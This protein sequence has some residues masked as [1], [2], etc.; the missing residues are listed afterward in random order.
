M[1]NARV[2]ITVAGLL[3]VTT[4]AR[5]A[6]DDYHLVSQAQIEGL[7]TPEPA[8][9]SPFKP[10][11]R[12]PS[13]CFQLLANTNEVLKSQARFREPI[14]IVSWGR[15]S[16]RRWQ[17]PPSASVQRVP[18]DEKSKPDWKHQLKV[19]SAGYQDRVDQ[20]DLGIKTFNL[21]LTSVFGALKVFAAAGEIPKW[22]GPAFTLSKFLL[23][24]SREQ[25]KAMSK[26]L[27]DFA[28]YELKNKVNFV[29][30][31]TPISGPEGM[32]FVREA[33]YLEGEVKVLPVQVCTAPTE[34]MLMPK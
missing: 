10:Y 12:V 25:N 7:P 34:P 26:F 32:D 20:Q 14:A 23:P 24:D 3:L 1:C 15:F 18:M 28:D 5:G 16:H 8:L 31:V 9:L 30:A 13:N 29:M 33:Y 21:L 19:V 17:G 2:A 4:I 11:Q 6:D 27:A 22:V